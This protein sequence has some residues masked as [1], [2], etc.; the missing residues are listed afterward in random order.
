MKCFKLFLVLFISLLVL[1]GGEAKA[2]ED[3]DSGWVA[4]YKPNIPVIVDG[5]TCDY[6]LWLCVRCDAGPYPIPFEVKLNCRGPS[7][8]DCVLD[9][10]KSIQAIEDII[11]DPQWIYD[12]LSSECF[13]GWPPCGQY[14]WQWKEVIYHVPVCWR[15]YNFIDDDKESHMLLEGCTDMWCITKYDV[16]WDGENF[17]KIKTDGPVIDGTGICLF[18]EPA[19]PDEEEYSECW[20]I[21]GDCWP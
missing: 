11:T 9:V 7:D 16:C 1:S 2:Q 3:C 14:P 4:I 21:E 5:D 13:A 18:E 20:Y 8:N 17:Q 12:N 10:P 15:K 19:D 6:D